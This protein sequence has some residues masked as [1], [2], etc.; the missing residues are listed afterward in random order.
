MAIGRCQRAVDGSRQTV[1]SITHI[2][3][4]SRICKPNFD[5]RQAAEAATKYC[6]GGWDELACL[7]APGGQSLSMAADKG[8]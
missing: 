5:R 8:S 2:F 7:D 1:D 4:T 6:M 3:F